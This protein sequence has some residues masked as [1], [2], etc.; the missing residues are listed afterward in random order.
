MTMP[1]RR[2]WLAVAATLCG[3]K[4]WSVSA[5]LGRHALLVGVG[6]V[7][8]LPERLW[9]EGPSNDVALM[10]EVLLLQG[11][12][13][14][15]VR[16]LARGPSADAAP[17]F[18][19]IR[20]AMTT[21][22]QYAAPGVQLVVYLA[23]HGAQVPQSSRRVLAEADGQE[24]VFLLEDV[25]RWQGDARSGFLPNALRDEDLA[26]WVDRLC[27]RGAEVWVFLDTCHAAGFLRGPAADVGLRV[28]SVASSELGV[29]PASWEQWGAHAE[30]PGNPRRSS[31]SGSPGSRGAVGLPR[32]PQLSHRVYATASRAKEGATEERFPKEPRLAGRVYGT[33]T[34]QLAALVRSQ[35]FYDAPSLREGLRQLYAVMGRTSPVPQVLGDPTLR[36]S[37]PRAPT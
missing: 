37:R 2:Q 31:W 30:K 13:A 24:E 26:A 18:S 23:G 20:E 5:P 7:D 11:F 3:D 16:V 14:G 9:L 15:Q 21:M 33:F 27:R 25:Q 19:A 22:E 28:R 10:R 12:N 36:W 35:G 29:P 6:R 34:W 8:A 1:T 32:Q 17:T 4:S